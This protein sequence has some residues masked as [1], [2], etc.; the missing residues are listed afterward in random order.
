MPDGTAAPTI[1]YAALAGKAGAMSSPPPPSRSQV[2]YTALAKQAGATSSTAASPTLGPSTQTPAPTDNLSPAERRALGA[3]PGN[4]LNLQGPSG[5][6]WKVSGQHVLAHGFPARESDGRRKTAGQR[7]G[8]VSAVRRSLDLLGGCWR[9]RGL[10]RP[11]GRF[12]QECA[13]HGRRHDALRAHG[14]CAV[15]PVPRT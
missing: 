10:N 13:P 6:G 7:R 2:D 12:A 14:S 3:R 11:A 9:L 4:P 1:D 15:L 5:S 8:M